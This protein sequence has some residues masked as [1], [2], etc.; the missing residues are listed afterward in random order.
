LK[1]L[2]GLPNKGKVQERKGKIQVSAT[3]RTKNL[4]GFPREASWLRKSVGWSR[5]K[6][7]YRKSEKRVL[8]SS[9]HPVVAGSSLLTAAKQVR[10]EKSRPTRDTIAS[11]PVRDDIRHIP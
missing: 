7:G 11:F 1:G 4:E 6:T 2:G 5:K 8:S 9:Q 3:D 10:G